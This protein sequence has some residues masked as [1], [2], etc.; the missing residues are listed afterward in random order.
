MPDARAVGRLGVA[1]ASGK[2]LRLPGHELAVQD[3]QLLQWHAGHWPPVA[4][5][6]R[7]REVEQ[8][9]H[10]SRLCRLTAPYSVRRR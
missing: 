6:I 7:V 5:Q 2:G 8:A 10:G 4:C 9:Q 1:D 3:E